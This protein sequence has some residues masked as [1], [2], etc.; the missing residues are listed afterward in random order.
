VVLRYQAVNPE[1]VRG[2]DG[3]TVRRIS[4]VKLLEISPVI[5]G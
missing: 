1:F 2:A 3:E 4:E 5:W